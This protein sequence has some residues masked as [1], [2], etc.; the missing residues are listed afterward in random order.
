MTYPS[1]P[2]PPT[3][4]LLVTGGTGTLGGH[5]VPL[6]RAAGHEVRV[7]TRRPRPDEDGVTYVT[8]DLLTGEG[9]EAAVD[10]VHTVLHL[11]GGPKG[12]D[13]ATRTLVRA[14]SGADVRHLVYIS[15]V[16]ADSVPLAWLRTKLDSE[17]AIA[18]SGIPWTVLRA[19]Q[20]HELTL[21][22][23]EKMTKLPV[24]PV[25]G[26]LRLQP[27]DSREVAARLAELALAAPAGRVPD[28]TGPEVHDLAALARPYLALHARRRRPHLPVRIPGK[29]GRA[30]REGANLT[31]QGA[32]TGRRT[33]EEF[34]TERAGRG[35][36]AAAARP[37]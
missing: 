13:R 14:A 37:A 35:T 26:G 24:L 2:S 33:W 9:V 30:Y 5:V 29:A 20:F 34:L 27:V 23:I 36:V 18:D 6:L 3:T 4:P 16:G 11:A 10:G 15:V 32:R 1:Y 31:L 28:M 21:T 19:A 7:L 25:P 8:G 12:D 22:M 17:R